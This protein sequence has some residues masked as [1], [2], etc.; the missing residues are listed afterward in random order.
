MKI[1]QTKSVIMAVVSLLVISAVTMGTANAQFTIGIKAA[2][3]ASNYNQ[4]TDRKFGL[5]AGVFMRLGQN[6]YFQPEVN[7][8]LRNLIIVLDLFRNQR[9][10]FRVKIL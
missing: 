10:G 4:L 2:G 3:N 8:S 1:I 5:E 7:Y 9:Y 6:F